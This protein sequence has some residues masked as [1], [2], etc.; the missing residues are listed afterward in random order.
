VTALLAV[1]EVS[2]RFGGVHALRS[3]S[4]EVA[5]GRVAGLIGPNGAGKSTLFDVV[6]GLRAPATGRV[7]MDGRDITGSSPQARAR[8]GMARTF[9]R[10]ELFGELTVRQHLVVAHRVRHRQ[11]RLALDLLGLGSRPRPGED[12]A[13]DGVLDLLGLGS[14]AGAPARALP[15]GTGRLVEVARAVA[16]EPRVILLDEPSSGLDGAETERLAAV[17]GRLRAERAVALLLVEHNVDLVLSL[18]DR[19]TVVD[20]GAVIAD[21]TPD[22]IRADQAVQR[23]YLGAAP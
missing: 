7:L 18:A 19:V 8:L 21:G 12:D 2:V 3:V 10:L 4:L 1:E 5:A 20:F 11:A 15:I 13:V 14:I 9:Q 6:S 22:D 23:A 17:L 16:T